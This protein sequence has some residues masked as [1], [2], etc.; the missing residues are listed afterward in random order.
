M[1]AASSAP[2][3]RRALPAGAPR[4]PPLAPSRV[5]PLLPDSLLTRAAC[6]PTPP[7]PLRALGLPPAGR[8]A[9]RRRDHRRADGAPPGPVHLGAR[10]P[11]RLGLD[12]GRGA[13]P[14]AA[15]P[16]LHRHRLLPFPAAPPCPCA[17]PRRIPAA[18][19]AGSPAI[20]TPHTSPHSSS[21]SPPQVLLCVSDDGTVYPYG[22]A[23]DLQPWQFSFGAQVQALG[24]AEAVVWPSGVLVVCRNH[25]M[26]AVTDLA[27]PMPFRLRDLPPEL[28]DRHCMAVVEPQ[29]TANGGLEVLVAAGD[30]VWSVSADGV[31][32]HG[33]TFGKVVSMAVSP[34]GA[35]LPR[36]SR[37]RPHSR[38]P[39]RHCSCILTIAEGRRKTQNAGRHPPTPAGLLVALFSEDGKLWVLSADMQKNLTE[40]ATRA[41]ARRAPPLPPGLRP[42]LAPI[43]FP[44]SCLR[45]RPSP[46]R[47]L[48]HRSTRRTVPARAARVVRLGLRGAPLA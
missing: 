8:R 48:P 38:S 9:L 27:Q 41:K 7:E 39:S 16:L 6:P 1:I 36:P 19:L 3:Q 15:P 17:S 40:F 21:D 47:R 45:R 20:P 28:G 25:E 5:P 33:L 29:L 34:N 13:P 44:A 35:R 26:Y 42:P 12:R 18:S 46:P 14:R 37:H 31:V 24:V 11:H 23:G 4:A 10:P 2:P 22:V 30:T 43:L 32:D